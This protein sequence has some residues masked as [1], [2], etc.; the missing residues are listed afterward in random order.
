MDPAETDQVR[1]DGTE[2]L[3]LHVTLTGE[4]DV[5]YQQILENV[6]D[7]C[8]SSGRFALIDLS[9]VTFMDSRCVRELAIQYLLSDGRLVL[10]DPSREVALSVAACE[11][12]DCL[13]FFCT[14]DT[15]C[16]G[17]P[18]DGS[19]RPVRGEDLVG[20]RG[21]YARHDLQ[22]ALPLGYDARR[23]AG[24]AAR[25]PLPAGGL[26]D[27]GVLITGVVERTR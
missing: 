6:L 22:R 10:C 19:L 12:E 9:G 15:A 23:K 4:L 20:D 14:T 26:R 11:L 8:V 13:D 24:E 25:A 7:D 18:A 3:P 16:G 5:R 1:N 21:P 27:G 17:R 2:D